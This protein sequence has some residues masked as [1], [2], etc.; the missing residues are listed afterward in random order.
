MVGGD[1]DWMVDGVWCGEPATAAGTGTVGGGGGEAHACAV[2]YSVMGGL[3]TL[4]ESSY[5]GI[6]CE[7]SF[8]VS[9]S[10]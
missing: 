5:G 3:F 8:C 9:G 2:C 1:S 10:R 6:L 7:K 4:C